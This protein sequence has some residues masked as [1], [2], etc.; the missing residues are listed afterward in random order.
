METEPE[1]ARD[2]RPPA[3]VALGE[4]FGWVIVELAP[5]GIVVVDETGR[6]I[7]ANSK[8]E[9][10]FGHSRARLVGARVEMLMPNRFRN[11]HFHIRREYSEAPSARP[12]AIG[13]HLHGL[14]ADGSEFPVEISLSP[15]TTGAGIQTVVVIRDHTDHEVAEHA[16]R[17]QAKAED[18]ERVALELNTSV[19]H[20]IYGV[21]LR[22][23][24]L[25][26]QVDER[27]AEALL[28]AVG[29]LDGAVNAIRSAVFSSQAAPTRPSEA[30]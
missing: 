2:E 29:D 15:I 16:T 10:M 12:M 23:A 17:T 25:V 30:T 21:G 6:I 14:R 22:I 19:I 4:H 8:I 5:D 18:R 9:K 24:G 11:S 20:T 26:S 7:L 1:S 3:D 13:R 27:T 28:A